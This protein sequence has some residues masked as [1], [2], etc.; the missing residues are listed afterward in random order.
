M[1]WVGVLKGEG[2]LYMDE[3]MKRLDELNRSID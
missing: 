1:E 2:V 3:W